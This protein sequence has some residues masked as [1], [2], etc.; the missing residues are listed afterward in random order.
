MSVYT[1]SLKAQAVALRAWAHSLDVQVGE[2][3]AKERA[4]ATK[5]PKATKPPRPQDHEY[6]S[7]ELTTVMIMG[8]RPKRASTRAEICKHCSVVRTANSP[9]RFWV[10]GGWQHAK[11]AC[12]GAP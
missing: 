2:R 11:P 8:L 12:A 9:W 4:A 6:Q 1:D 3:E 5:P 10:D 7:C